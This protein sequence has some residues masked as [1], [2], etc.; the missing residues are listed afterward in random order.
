MENPQKENGYTSIANEIME[1]M[2]KVNLN[3]YQMR[4]LF[5]VW[6]KTYGFNKSEDW[7]ANSQ[8]IEL[9]GLLKGHVS[10]AKKQLIQ[11]KILVTSLGNKIKFNKYYSQW[12]ELPKQ[13]TVTKSGNKVTS[14]GTELPNEEPKLPNEGDTKETIQKKLYTKEIIPKGI[15]AK[16]KVRSLEIDGILA[17]L[18]KTMGIDDFKESQK[19]QRY[20]AKHIGSLGAKIGKEEFAKRFSGVLSEPFKR[21]NCNSIQFLY[22]EIK[23]FM[24][25]QNIPKF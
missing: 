12:I 4:L 5:A 7:I 8:L 11:R 10:R 13:V 3:S 20:T 6:R 21:K 15:T 19:Q 25:Q 14:I 24:P 17:Y 2:C 23:A 1:A 9:T 22:R 16:P 18:K